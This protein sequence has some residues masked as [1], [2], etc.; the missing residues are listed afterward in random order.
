MGNRSSE[1]FPAEEPSEEP[2]FGSPLDIINDYLEIKSLIVE[3]LQK[4]VDKY[5]E[6]W[7]NNRKRLNIL[8]IKHGLSPGDPECF[9]TIK[10]MAEAAYNDLDQEL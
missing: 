4:T 2:E 9:K 6:I 1:R 7:T 3:L 10:A 8:L 5:P